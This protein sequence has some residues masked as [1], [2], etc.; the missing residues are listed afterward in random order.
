MPEDCG[1]IWFVPPARPRKSSPIPPASARS[2][3]NL[4]GNA[5]K[6]TTAGSVELRILAASSSTL[7][8][9]V[10]DT[11]PGIAESGHLFR[12]FEQ[13]DAVPARD[14][15]A[16]IGLPVTEEGAG[17]GLAIA[18]RFVALMG[19]TI[20]YRANPSGGSIFWHKVARRATA[21]SRTGAGSL[22]ETRDVA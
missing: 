2:S 12:E 7:H 10:A 22:T 3:L 13:R 19:G 16:A 14:I 17:P 15:T 5:V 11:G 4:L 9:E 8:M 20:G 18:A 6:F 1:W 21:A